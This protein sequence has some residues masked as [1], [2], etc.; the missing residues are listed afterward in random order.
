MHTYKHKIHLKYPSSERQSY[1]HIWIVKPTGIEIY[2]LLIIY[3]AL[4]NLHLH[5]MI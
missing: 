4:Q 1:F 3:W 2:I 5:L